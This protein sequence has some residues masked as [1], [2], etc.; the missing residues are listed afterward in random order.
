MGLTNLCRCTGYEEIENAVK[1][2]LTNSING[3][4]KIKITETT[5]TDRHPLYWYNRESTLQASQIP[6]L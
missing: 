5:P 4:K 2:I 3:I 6:Y 1:S